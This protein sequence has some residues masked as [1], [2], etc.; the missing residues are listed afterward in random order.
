MKGKVFV[1]TNILIYAHDLDAGEKYKIANDLVID[2]WESRR[3]V[4]STQVLLEFYVTLTKKILKPLTGNIAAGIISSYLSWEVIINKPENI[5][6]AAEI[7]SHYQ[8]SFWDA[9]IVSAAYEGNVKTII[10]EDLN[11][12][13]YM[14]GIKIMNPFLD[15]HC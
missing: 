5:L 6:L 2:L 11:H 14:E 15:G 8:I 7:E 3:A 4:I 12:G 9:V 10:S 13:Q 1:D